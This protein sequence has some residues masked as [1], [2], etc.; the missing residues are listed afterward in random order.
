M[1]DNSQDLDNILLS[2]TKITMHFF[3]KIKPSKL[4]PI[5]T[6]R[7][8]DEMRALGSGLVIKDCPGK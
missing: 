4:G 7:L 5:L 8:L 2:Y 3:K 6:E 1:A